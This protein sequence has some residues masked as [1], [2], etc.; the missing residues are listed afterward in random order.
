MYEKYFAGISNNTFEEFRLTS[1]EVLIDLANNKQLMCEMLRNIQNSEE[2]IK[3]SESYD[4]LDKFT[5]YSNNEQQI[6]ARISVFNNKYGNR[7]HYHRWD[8]SSYI[9]KGGYTQYIY[10]HLQKGK[11][12]IREACSLNPIL[13]EELQ[14]GNLYSLDNSVI[15]SV[16]AIPGSVSICIRGKSQRDRF[17]VI[18]TRTDTEWWQYGQK[19]EAFEEH[20]VKQISF[21][22]LK[23]KV[24]RTCEFLGGEKNV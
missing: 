14:E 3:K 5:I 10:G 15:H 12:L 8:Y 16:K 19:L 9:L 11:E 17:Q 18:D 20:Q 1:R 2:L 13:V 22:D 7:I 23:V 21:E 24:N 6:Y 4:F